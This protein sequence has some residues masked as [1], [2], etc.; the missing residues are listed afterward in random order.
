MTKLIA[1]CYFILV[2]T[3]CT[4]PARIEH[5]NGI[6]IR[7]SEWGGGQRYSR[8]VFEYPDG[9]IKAMTLCAGAIPVWV[10]AQFDIDYQWQSDECYQITAVRRHQ[11]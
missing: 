10:G 7:S 9:S 5:A 1:A 2:L 11:Q 3:S 8:I 6:T 4:T